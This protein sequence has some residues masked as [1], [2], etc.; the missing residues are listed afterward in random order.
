MTIWSNEALKLGADTVGLKGSPTWVS[1]IF[2]PE[3]AKG[4]IVGD[5]EADP[6]GTARLLVETLQG[7]D[8]LPF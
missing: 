7:K 5:G 8:L 3:R 4:Q 2:S 1:R 6:V